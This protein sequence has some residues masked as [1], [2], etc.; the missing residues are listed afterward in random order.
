MDA[1]AVAL[2]HVLVAVD[3]DAARLGVGNAAVH[4]RA[5]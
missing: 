5:S 2:S 4:R 3:R 1:E